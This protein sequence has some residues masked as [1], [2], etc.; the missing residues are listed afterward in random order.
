M[1]PLRS[2]SWER[3]RVRGEYGDP[4]R[5]TTSVLDPFFARRARLL[6]PLERLLR[7]HRMTNAPVPTKATTAVVTARWRDIQSF[8]YSR[9]PTGGGGREGGEGSGGGLMES[10][11]QGVVRRASFMEAA[12]ATK[13]FSMLSVILLT[14]SLMKAKLGMSFSGEKP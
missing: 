14:S 1:K 4:A 5:T 10:G 7:L 11:S 8:E 13:W 3:D 6:A 9:Y 12:T 2:R